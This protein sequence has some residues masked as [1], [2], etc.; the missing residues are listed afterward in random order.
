MQNYFRITAYHPTENISVIMDS[1]G[2]FEKLWQFSSYMVSKGFKVL[3]VDTEE[4]FL[5]G[6]LPKVES[7]QDKIILRASQEGKPNIFD[8]IED[9]KSYH[10]IIIQDANYLTLKK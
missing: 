7:K 4:T 3:E 2:K 8:Y 1:Y 9:N 6:N 10:K 5:D